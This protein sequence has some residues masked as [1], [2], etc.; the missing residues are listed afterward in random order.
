VLIT[1][2]D[3]SIRLV[4]INDGKQIQKYKGLKN[5]DYM[6]RASFEEIY[7]LVI[8]AS[9]DGY[10]YVWKKVN[11]YIFFINSVLGHLPLSKINHTN[12]L[13][14]LKIKKHHLVLFSPT[15]FHYLPISRRFC[16]LHK[17]F[18]SRA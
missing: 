5:D 6:I 13:N 18:L 8:S 17:S 15:I 14:P 16:L 1:T 3:S 9:D 7:D 12:I 11:Q 4:D 2:N 10:V